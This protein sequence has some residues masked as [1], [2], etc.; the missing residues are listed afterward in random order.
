[1]TTPILKLEL[2][3]AEI[4]MCFL[5]FQLA[6]QDRHTFGEI[7]TLMNKIQTQAN[8]QLQALN[9]E[10]KDAPQTLKTNKPRKGKAALVPAALNATDTHH[11]AV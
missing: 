4:D 3:L 10:T 11:A 1:M 7:N 2:T 5:L 9:G 8:P 6:R